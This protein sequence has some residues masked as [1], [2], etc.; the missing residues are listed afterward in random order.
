ML[1]LAMHHVITD[2]W[3][4]GILT[5]ELSVLYAAA[6]HGREPELEPLPV[7]YAD[8]A[9][10]QRGQLTDTTLAAGLD[11]WTGQLTGLAPLELPADR[12]RPPVRTPAG[13]TCQ[14]TIP[15]ETTTALKNLA[16]AHDATLF[17]VLTAATQTLLSRWTGQDDIAIGT[18]VAG[19]D[20]AELEHI[21]GF[22]V[23][24]I[25]LRTT[26]N[27]HDTFTTLLTHVRDTTLDAF[28][29]QHIPFERVVDALQ[30]DRDTSRTP[31][32]QAMILLQNT[33]ATTPARPGLS[34]QPVPQPLT[35]AT[36]DLV[37]EFREYDGGL[38]AALTYSTDLFDTATAE[39]MATHLQVLLAAIAA[40][41]GQ[42]VG[43]IELTTPAERAQVLAAG[44]GPAGE[45]PSGTFPELFQAQA[46]RTP[47]A[48]ALAVGPVRLS[49]AQLNTRANQLARH[50]AAA[51]AGPERLIA[52]ALPRTAEMVT[53]IL[54]VHKTG[55]A[56]L[57][58][59]PALPPARISHLLTDAQPALII[60]TTA[61]DLPATATPRLFLDDPATMTALTRQPG[62]D[63]TGTSS[64]TPASTA[65][66]IYTSGS[67]GTPKGV[68][69]SHAGLANLHA[70]QRTRFLPPDG[71]QPLRAA[72]TASFSF[73]ASWEG[74]LLLASGHELHLINDQ[75]RTDP[76]ALVQYIADQH[77]DLVNTT[78]SYLDQL[79]AAGLLT[80]GQHQ[81]SIILP[82]AEPIP[83]RLWQALAT[84]PGTT[85]YNLYGPT[86]TTIDA[87][88]CQITGT[89]PAI[90]HP[91]HNTQVYL[92]DPDLRP[93]PPGIRG[94]LHIAG[95]GLARG[96]LNQPGLTAQRFTACPYGPPGQRMYAT[97]DLARWT[98]DGQLE[99]LGRADQQ[100]KIRG[101]RIEP[102]EIE[103]VLCQH[104][105]IAGA[106]VIAREDTP[107]R[108][109]LAAYLT[110]ATAGTA[111]T[112]TA[113][114][115]VPS[116]GDLRD[117]L[118]ATLPDY[119]IPAS[120]TVLDV[121][122]LTP[123]GKLDR[124]ALPAPDHDTTTG[125]VP[126]RT[127]AEQA[128][129]AI[130]ADVLGLDQVGIHDN[131]F[132]LGG[133]SILSIQIT[134]RLR[135]TLGADLSP[136]AIFTT[137]TK[138]RLA[139]LL[140][141]HDPANP[142]TLPIPVVPHDGPLPLSFAQQRL[143]FL[144]QF[145]PGSTQYVTAA[146]S[147]LTGP[148]DTTAFD[149]A[150]TTLI[151]RHG[152]LRTTLETRD[153][154]GVQLIH[155]PYD[156][157]VPLLDLSGLPAAQREAEI[158]AIVARDCS[159]PFDLRQG[160][161]IRVR[162]VRAAAEDH[163]LTLAMHHVITDGWSMGILTRELSTLYTAALHDREPGLE[164]L[165]VQ[166]ADYAIWQRGQLTDTTLAAGLDY[167]TGQLSGL[168]PLELPADRPRPPVRTPNGATCQFTIPAP[169]TTALK[170]LARSH[171]ATLFMVLTAATQTLL[172]RWTGQDDIAIGTAVAGRD[173]AELEHIIGF[174]VNTIVL[175]STVDSR[176]TFTSLL[177]HV[178][179][180][181]L[182][183]F[184]HQHIPF[185]RVVDALQPD[186]D[187]SRTPRVQAMILLQNTPAT[188][189]ALPGLCIQPV[190]QPLTTATVD[191]VAEFREYD[192]QLAA[193]LTYSTDLFDTATADRMATHLQ[194]LLAAIAADPG[195]PVGGIELA[196]PAEQAQV[197]TAGT[198]PASE[199]PAATFPDLFQAQA[200]R[201][202]GA[203][204]L[205]A[206][207][208]RLS[209]AQLNTRANQLARHLLAHDRADAG[210][211][212]ERLIAL[213]LPRTAEMVT[214]ILAVH[215]TGAAYLPID[216]A[217]PPARI[218]HLLT[219][220]QPA[221]II[222]TTATDPPA[223]TIPRLF[224]DD[225]ATI[226]AL[227]RQPDTDLTSPL[228]PASTAYVI[229]TSGSTGNPKG[230]IVT[231]T[232]LT[233]QHTAH[234]QGYLP[235]AGH[236]PQRDA[237]TASFSFDPS[238]EG[239]LLLAS[240]HE[241][242]L[243]QDQVRTDPYALVQYI[244]D[245]HIDIVNTTPSYLEQLLAAGLLA[246]QHHQPAIIL[247]GGEPVPAHLWQALATTPGTT[248]YNLYGPT[249]T[250]VEAT[251]S[252]ITT[253]TRPAIGR[254]L[255][256]TRVYVLDRY[257][258]PVPPGIPGQLY[259]AG[260]GLARGYLNQPGLTALRFTACPF[261][262]P[263]S[264]MYA[265]GD[266][267]RWT[268]DGELEYLGRADQQ[269]KIRG[270]RIEPGEIETVLCQHPAIA[271]A[272]VTAREDTPGRR[273][274]AAYLAPAAGATATASVPSAG[275]LR[276][277][278]SSTLPDYMIPATFTVLDALPL[279]PN[280]KLD[281]RALPH[282]GAPTTDYVPPRTPAEQAIAAIWADVLGLDQ[283]G[284][285]D[286]F[287]ELGGDSILSIQIVSRARQAGHQFTV[288]DLILHQTIAELAPRTTPATTSPAAHQPLTGPAPLTPIQHWFFQG[289]RGNPRHFN[290]SAL[291]ELP[292]DVDEAALRCALDALLTHHDA[293]RTQ[294]E[295]A[296]GEW[297]GRI[298]PVA[299]AALERRDLAEVDPREQEGVMEK[300]ANDVHTSFNLATGPL[301]KAVLFVR[302]LE[303]GPYL[304]LVAHHLV[305]DVV[306]WRILLDDLDVAYR[307]AVDRIPV[308]LGPATTSFP[309]W[310][311]RL[312]SHVAAGRLD[313]ELKH[314]SEV[315]GSCVPLPV[316]HAPAGL[317]G[318]E[319]TVHARLS[320]EETDALLRAAPTAYRT[321]IN[322]V[323]LAALA[324]AL[325][326]WTGT[327]RACIDL[328]GHG[329]EDLLDGVD[330]SRT[331][332]WFTT[333]FPVTL[334]VPGQDQPGWRALIKS[335]RRQL[336]AVPGNGIGF[337]ALRHLSSAA[338][339]DRLS[340]S[341][342]PQIAFNYLG[343]FDA[344][345]ADAGGGL[346]R[347]VLGPLG[348][349]HEPSDHDPHL[350]QV[351]G[352]T[353]AGRLEF[354]WSYR[355]DVH[356][357]STVERIA[358]E[359]ADALRQI[360]R[361][362]LET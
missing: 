295:E 163:V 132:E 318:P 151:A 182:D 272:A 122:P 207:Q 301:F 196:T 54:A 74:L 286:N 91:L 48:T 312:G 120:F 205:V 328:E 83:A 331:V 131:F 128:I 140:P 229:Y 80:S 101:F 355:P 130:W 202:P 181:T 352:A 70:S 12:P 58:I 137:P 41:P 313:G 143:W 304:F 208:A 253:A 158:T 288:K 184:A 186:R 124:R 282:P 155:P 221:L 89:R 25:V 332:G 103:T 52:L 53:A 166:Y 90:G 88:S 296:D 3:S 146:A 256:N 298:A 259:I 187:T 342:G 299:P 37:A 224:L 275:D 22:F 14:F 77:I 160:P 315:L 209:Y 38:A 357:P 1:T 133:D 261:G 105:A 324:W 277:W 75:V 294:F 231:H 165:P 71:H 118:A 291:I 239:L 135:T 232:G 238:W 84:A 55:A 21:I 59:D 28:A 114:T 125:Y 237:L 300:V 279:T 330:L 287:F 69:V 200:Q 362:C 15:A 307:Q 252:P 230:V 285:H 4:M 152:S 347:A 81:P 129:A 86:E 26:I 254:P 168:A 361:E 44:T 223:S 343:Q 199:I 94:Q 281:H 85:S 309:D 340:A 156:V 235:P 217:L 111:A 218:S 274:L 148:L 257:L 203:T 149:K 335:V 98:E 173:H 266:L 78:P 243:I 319:A 170:N 194:V 115:S 123:T 289:H 153:G 117:W 106:A 314:W 242:H 19:R 161:L 134:S 234:R 348:Q 310:A 323:L 210:A 174:F 358:G 76:D 97:G 263:G 159:A 325:C 65:Y 197:L 248:S 66:V 247:T 136:R 345:S 278:L 18:A 102:G 109:Q 303:Q 179:D 222:T 100:V 214:A 108:K 126:P 145:E 338:A 337:G 157:R 211:G 341:P 17:M 45:V 46:A 96:Y 154:R 356:D 95:A 213:A 93:V 113:A 306:S 359:F 167:W 284:I 121:L 32:F 178:R 204:A 164:P 62:T 110:P 190:P 42:P 61:T 316:D 24:T 142:A 260:A 195:Q 320:A 292:A 206:G 92:L 40:D 219:D 172:S 293:L 141:D 270:F 144:D 57:P 246:S 212:P 72:L 273:H 249:E 79:L 20:H 321:R 189:P 7:Q 47:D 63:L 2:G 185:E 127:P 339:R 280:G 258:R 112:G 308:D 193:A 104:P 349:D 344:R 43:G 16:R 322:D 36:V 119:M 334:E 29:H 225:P 64:L 351:V 360:A 50:L 333:V 177:T 180:T 33:P 305:I 73:D 107:G 39:R 290:Q 56:Y 326:R 191:L 267:A 317:A 6:L 175:R 265:T 188:T 10:W 228:T 244:A 147:R 11:Y 171:D 150:L 240:G 49:Y 264:R 269:V 354:T 99:Y 60:T 262:P 220:A 353:Q 5:Q 271:G 183:A 215:K 350:L 116:A 139:A 138:A 13:A 34:M 176:S 327:S 30:P 336:R 268:G 9:V 329:R 201:T 192:G 216:P 31:L 250:T 245:Q 255:H 346:G 67:T 162:L 198:G 226:T 251:S 35:T 227:A 302:G 241:L 23:N 311:E 169:V 87:V 236:Q 82:G 233:N 27:P 51:G 68:I 283:V 297:R 276:D 8:F